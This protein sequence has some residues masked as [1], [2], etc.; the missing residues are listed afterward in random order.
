MLTMSGDPAGFPYSGEQHV[1]ARGD[2][3]HLRHWWYASADE[4]VHADDWQGRLTGT[5]TAFGWGVT[6]N[7]FARGEDGA[8]WHWWTQESE[9][10]LVHRASW[11][12]KVPADA[13]PTGFGY[14]GSSMHVFT[15]GTDDHLQHF[16]YDVSD[17]EV[18]RDDWTKHAPKTVVAGNPVSFV[19][20]VQQ[21]VF[22]RDGVTSH[23]M[24]VLWSPASGF[25]LEDWT[26]LAQGSPVTPASD[27]F[28]HD[29]R[30][31]QH[32]FARDASG[33]LQH[34]Y[35]ATADNAIHREPWN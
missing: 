26:T 24:Q 23:L 1:F 27:P 16:W 29:A 9:A 13:S 4:K 2:D 12:G 14:A 33:R 22:F 17:G 30:T 35:Y 10:G 18:H 19:S 32:L 6:K 20:G 28:G 3:G 8:L 34:W 11:G 31:L 15:R 21:H 5:P 7:V 25:T